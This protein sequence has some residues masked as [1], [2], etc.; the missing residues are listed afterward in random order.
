MIKKEGKLPV[1]ARITIDYSG[2]KPKIK[3]G[4]PR[5]DAVRQNREGV[6]LLILLIFWLVIFVFLL[7]FVGSGFGETIENPKN[8]T[9]VEGRSDDYSLNSKISDDYNFSFTF[10]YPSEIQNYT[11][12]CNNNN[13]TLIFQSG[14]EYNNVFLKFFL[15]SLNEH[16]WDFSPRFITKDKTPVYLLYIDLA[17]FLVCFFGSIYLLFVLDK[18]IVTFLVKRDWF[19]KRIPEINRRLSFRGYQAIFKKVKNRMI[20]IPLFN[21]VYLDF[22]ATKEFSDYLQKIEIKEHPFN[23]IIVTK[24]RRKRKRKP[25]KGDRMKNITLWYAK[26]YFSKIPRTGR[27][28]VRWK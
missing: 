21:N 5:K 16:F 9:I 3:F 4:Y 12:Y 27:L 2:D 10:D 22:K 18:W 19:K 14:T 11:L 8:C 13:Y 15:Q 25:R 26:F 20:E 7:K 23:R 1:N 17:L 24:K 6:I 28:E